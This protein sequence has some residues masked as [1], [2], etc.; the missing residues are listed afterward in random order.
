MTR[1]FTVVI[2]RDEEGYLVASVPSLQGCHTQ[3]RSLDELLERIKEAI[4]L[5]LEVQGEEPGEPLELVGVQR[6]AV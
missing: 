5:C 1:E 6:V 4:R 3:A 2:E